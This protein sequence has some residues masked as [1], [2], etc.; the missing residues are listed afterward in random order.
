[1]ENRMSRKISI[2]II[3]L[4][5]ILVGIAIWF[6]LGRAQT[7]RHV[8]LISIDTC[9]A[10]RLSCYGYSRKTTPN[11]DVVAADGVLFENAVSPVPLTLPAHSSMLTGTIPP[12]HGVHRNGDYRLG[13]SNLTLAEILKDNGFATGAVVSAVVMERRFGLDQGFD[14]YG[15]EFEEILKSLVIRGAVEHRRGEEATRFA[16]RWLGE[17]KDERF[18]LFLHYFD[19][20][21]PYEPP[22]PFTSKFRYQPYA[23]EIAYADWCIGQVIKRLKEL[24]LYDSTLLIITSDHGESLDEHGEV[25]HGYFI[26]EGTIKVPLIFRLPGGSKGQRVGNVVGLI[27]IVPTVLNVLGIE[28]PKEVQGKDLS[29]CFGGRRSLEEKRFVF[30]QSFYPGIYQCN[31]L[32]GV[33]SAGWKYIQTTRPELYDLKNDPKE[34]QNLVDEQPHRAR[35]MQG[36]LSQILQTQVRINGG[37]RQSP[38]DQEMRE[39]LESLGYVSTGGLDVFFEFDQTKEDPKD[40]VTFHVEQ[41]NVENF[42]CEEKFEQAGKLAGQ[43]VSKYENLAFSHFLFGNVVFSEGKF[44]E[45]ATYYSRAVE[46]WP[47]FRTAHVKLGLAYLR[48]EKLEDAVVH[49]KK[50]LRLGGGDVNLHVDVAN[51]LARLGRVDE[52]IEHWDMSLQLM[53]DLPEV[54]NKLAITYYQQQKIADAVKHWTEALK[55]NPDQPS[56]LNDLAWVYAADKDSQFHKP[57]EAVKL[58]EKACELTDFERPDFLDTLSVAYASVGRFAEAI[59]IAQ[60]AIS[61]AEAADQP[62]LVEEIKEHLTRYRSGRF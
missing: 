16:C 30:C 1:M 14:Y 15:D 6:F 56:V 31:S 58:A 20:H 23:G 13:Q 18:F 62:E 10:D 45:A 3:L 7:V 25:T 2:F 21:W 34:M 47:D 32:L 36:E 52:A 48:T 41:Y 12:Y 39:R 60:K 43:L 44:D 9:R 49:W 42:I 61:L 4:L 50:A 29:S 51:L 37:E 55:L 38:M 54:H 28:V 5:V 57:A 33:V 40:Y 46:L 11:I 24:D 26:Y 59:E 53:P 19:P 27:D 35:L 8:V 22:E 17:N